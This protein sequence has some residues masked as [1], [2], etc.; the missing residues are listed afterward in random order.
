LLESSAIK[1]LSYI[2]LWRT[3]LDITETFYLWHKITRFNGE[4]REWKTWQ[5]LRLY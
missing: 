1:N 5:L 2:N 3:K 4:L